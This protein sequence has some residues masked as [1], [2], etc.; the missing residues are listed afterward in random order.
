MGAAGRDF[1]NFNLRFRD[2]PSC[3][4]V[5]FTATQIPFAAGR[6]YPPTLAGGLY[7]A[8]IPIVDESELPGLLRREAVDEVVFAY[9][10][11]S[12]Q[13]LM[14][15]GSAV[16]AFGADFRFLGPASV[17]LASARPVISVCAVRTGCGK[18][19]LSRRICALVAALGFRAVVMRHP[20]PYGDLESQAMQ[21]FGSLEDLDLA[22][23]TLEEREEYEPHLA[24]GT[25]VFAGVDYRRV[26]AAAASEG[27]VIVWDGGNN[28]FPFLRPDLEIVLLDPTRPGD[29]TGYFPGEVNLLRAGVLVIGKCNLVPAETVEAL[30]RA[31][32]AKNPGAP[33]VRMGSVASVAEPE[34]VAGKR[35]LVV[36][37]GP[38]ITHGGLAAGA[39]L[40]LARELGGEVVDPRRFSVGSIR[41][42]YQAYPHL[43]PVL[44][45]MGYSERQLAELAETIDRVP[46]DLLLLAT[47]ADLGRLFRI[48]RPVVRVRYELT[49]GE[50]LG[51]LVTEILRRPGRRAPSPTAG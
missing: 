42:V 6:T 26:L 38:S 1:H 13:E 43:G 14:H 9:S 10:D 48:D 25:P 3:E 34:V 41:Q 18:S 19:G 8:G 17:M 12:H 2:D 35:V 32:R 4:V 23:C 45:A 39:G 44:P 47:P 28:D 49:G 22:R 20:M 37:D 50:E 5:A 7:P 51:T 36:E 15:K 21:R 27:E 24:D 33:I 16:L 29:E 40:A 11:I 46:C 31:A 30:A